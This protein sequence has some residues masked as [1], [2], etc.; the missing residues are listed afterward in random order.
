[1]S[2]TEST[3]NF[4]AFASKIMDAPIQHGY[5]WPLEESTPSTTPQLMQRRPQG[6]R[7]ERGFFPNKGRT[8]S[9]LQIQML[10]TLKGLKHEFKL[11]LTYNL[12]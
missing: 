2:S 1:M 4:K 12:N 9:L 5:T 11:L 7:L 6:L 10:I 8:F 3:T